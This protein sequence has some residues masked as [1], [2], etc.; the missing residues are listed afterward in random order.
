MR[1]IFIGTIETKTK[2]LHTLMIL[3]EC[4]YKP[5]HVGRQ[6]Y[7]ACVCLSIH[8]PF[9]GTNQVDGN[10]ICGDKPELL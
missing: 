8:S 7:P 1:K 3:G 2:R 4:E 5:T 10:F 6:R 9:Y